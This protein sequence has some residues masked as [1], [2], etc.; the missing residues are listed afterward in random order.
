MS[1]VS[2]ITPTIRPDG[3]R[4]VEK[5]L[6]NQE[7]KDF[8]WIIIAPKEEHAKIQKLLSFPFILI[9]EPE[10]KDSDV[11]CLNKAYNAGIKEA[12]GDLIVSWQDWTYSKY[13]TLGRFLAHFEQDPSLLIGAVGNKYK[14]VYPELGAMIWKDPRERADQGNFY[15]TGFEN[16]E[17][18]LC[19]VSKQALL[20]VGGFDEELD[21]FY[22]MDGYSVNERIYLRGGYDF[23]L[24]QSIKSYSVIHGRA[25][26]W[27]ERNAIHGP[28]VERRKEYAKNGVVLP[29]LNSDT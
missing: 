4:L 6:S 11:W 23:A 2:V 28:Y 29:Y 20:D 27:E 19:S 21:K 24:D 8:E 12:S 9:K 7:M 14:T 18:N 17:W 3:L 10:M 5:S 22:G 1:K 25:P 26:D 16:V 15:L 13:D